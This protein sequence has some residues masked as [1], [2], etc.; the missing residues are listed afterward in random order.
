MR[1]TLEKNVQTDERTER[2][3]PSDELWDEKEEHILK[4]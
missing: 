2:R 1:D 4:I 3:V